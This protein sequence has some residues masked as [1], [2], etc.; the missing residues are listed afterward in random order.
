MSTLPASYRYIAYDVGCDTLELGLLSVGSTVVQAAAAVLWGPVVEWKPLPCLIL[1]VTSIL[2]G[3]VSCCLGLCQTFWQLM[4]L[5][6]LRGGLLASVFPSVDSFISQNFTPKTRGRIYSVHGII[7]MCGVIVCMLVPAIVSASGIKQSKYCG[8]FRVAFYAVG[9]CSI[10]AG[11]VTLIAF[12]LKLVPVSIPEK[13]TKSTSISILP[14]LRD[15]RKLSKSPLYI[16]IVVQE[17]IHHIPRSSL[18]FLLF[19]FQSTDFPEVVAAVIF[20]T[21]L[22]SNTGGIAL[23]GVLGD[24]LG[25]LYRR[26]GKYTLFG[27][28]LRPLISQTSTIVAAGLFTLMLFVLPQV[29]STTNTLIWASFGVGIPAFI[30]MGPPTPSCHLPLISH[31]LT[32]RK[33]QR[34]A[35]L[36]FGVNYAIGALGRAVGYLFVGI[37]YD[38]LDF[39]TPSSSSSSASSTSSSS[40]STPSSI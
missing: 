19:A 22:V 34:M 8:A 18:E 3:T 16:L 27:Y 4:I 32:F 1:G 39:S 9:G 14:F 6:C 7:C 20:S 24:K 25:G 38:T 11:V 40:F 30:A 10:L 26:G 21:F 28:A 23:G 35:P 2:W 5:L 13:E 15:L 36:A 17:F 33:D 29:T 12:F 37:M 31:L